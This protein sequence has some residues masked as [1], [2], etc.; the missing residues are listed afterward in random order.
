VDGLDLC[1]DRSIRLSAAEVSSPLGEGPAQLTTSALL[2][3]W[4]ARP[5]PCEH[6]T[7]QSLGVTCGALGG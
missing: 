1:H 5:G 6:R 2:G 7:S 4:V 3:C